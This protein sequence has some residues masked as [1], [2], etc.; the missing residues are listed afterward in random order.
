MR[1][2]DKLINHFNKKPSAQELAI[3]DLES[4]KRMYLAET[5][6]AKYHTKMAEYY[7]ETITRLTAYIGKK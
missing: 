6:S 1:F 2:I 3:A 5:A 7:S 4:A